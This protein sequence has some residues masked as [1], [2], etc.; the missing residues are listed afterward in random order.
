MD[1]R[2]ELHPLVEHRL[3]RRDVELPMLVV[4]RDLDDGAG[5]CATC[6]S[7]IQFDAYSALPVRIRSPGKNR[8]A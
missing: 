3:E 7:A 2:D 1:K 4:G 8:N 6:F 5:A